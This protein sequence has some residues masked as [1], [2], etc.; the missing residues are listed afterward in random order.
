MGN[1]LLKSILKHHLQRHISLFSFFLYLNPAFAQHKI[2]FR[3]YF[4]QQSRSEYS[5][6]YGNVKDTNTFIVKTIKSMGPDSIEVV[7][8][9]KNNE[10]IRSLTFVVKEDSI[11]VCRGSRAINSKLFNSHIENNLWALNKR[12]KIKNV[13]FDIR[14]MDTC[15]TLTLDC[16]WEWFSQRQ[17][18]CKTG[19]IRLNGQLVKTITLSFTVSTLYQP[20]MFSSTAGRTTWNVSYVFAKGIGLVSLTTTSKKPALTNTLKLLEH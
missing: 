7:D 12:G 6:K 2:N 4:F 1:L 19:T 20:I 15:S 13:L 18:G 16:Y 8:F 11:T 10:F 14:T 5:L 3:D 9:D 17:S